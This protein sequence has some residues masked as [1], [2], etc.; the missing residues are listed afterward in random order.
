VLWA[1]RFLVLALGPE[2]LSAS[3]SCQPHHGRGGRP[4]PERCENDGFSPVSVSLGSDRAGDQCFL[5]SDV[6]WL[7]LGPGTRCIDVEH[8]S[9]QKRALGKVRRD[10]EKKHLHPVLIFGM[11]TVC[12]ALGQGMAVN[13]TQ[14][15]TFS[16]Y[17]PSCSLFLRL[18]RR[19]PERAN[20][21]PKIT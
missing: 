19:G 20:R 13:T 18:G 14:P 12:L 2:L 11:P 15:S 16:A 10:R 7:F 8:F 6:Y 4:I 21:E 1:A 9:D 5:K 17:G 3:S